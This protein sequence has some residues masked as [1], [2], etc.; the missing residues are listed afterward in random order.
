MESSIGRLPALLTDQR[1]SVA[2]LEPAVCVVAGMLTW[3]HRDPFD[4][5]LAATAIHD[6]LPIVSADAILDGMVPGL[7]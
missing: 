4:R 3:P 1:G 6:S 7:W 2:I 5:L